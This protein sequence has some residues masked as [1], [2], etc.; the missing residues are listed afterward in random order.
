M[1]RKYWSASCYHGLAGGILKHALMHTMQT[2]QER[3][4]NII[5]KQKV[6]DRTA[7][8]SRMIRKAGVIFS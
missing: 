2:A 7:L 8:Y 6:R 5:R 4:Q 3:A 1:A